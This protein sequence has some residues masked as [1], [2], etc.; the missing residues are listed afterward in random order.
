M[1][2]LFGQLTL[3]QVALEKFL[4]CRRLFR[5]R[6]VDALYWPA[7]WGKGEENLREI[8]RGNTF[9]RLAQQYY[10][11]GKVPPVREQDL[12]RW[13]TA[14]AGRWPR[15]NG[16][17]Y[18]PE[19]ELRWQSPWG[20]LLVKYD[21]LVVTGD[22]RLIIFDWKTQAA[23]LKENYLRERWQ[24]RLYLLVAA[25]CG[26]DYLGLAPETKISL[27]YWNPR[28][29]QQ[30]VMLPGTKDF[31]DLSERRV[32]Q[33]LTEIETAIAAADYPPVG[34]P[35]VCCSCEY[36]PLCQGQITERPTLAEEL[37]L[38]GLSW[39]SLEEESW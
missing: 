38:E 10:L 11:T 28:F 8:E 3:S 31:L 18:Y 4:S 19:Q 13:M 25:R 30:P 32:Q 6:Y 1:N 21:L 12:S 39:D 14:L 24:T 33:V 27:V 7:V 22:G 2:S 9:H 37:G 16:F 36:R 26:L 5:Y 20:R 23:P 29:P 17:H 35:E 34:V 15:Q